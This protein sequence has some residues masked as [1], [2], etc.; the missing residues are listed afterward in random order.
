MYFL[1][2]GES[3]WNKAQANLDAIGMLSD[4]DH[5]LDQTGIQQ[6]QE[7]NQKW[8]DAASRDEDGGQSADG[9][10]GGSED[11]KDFLS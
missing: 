6:C 9:E 10:E 1:R 4:V 11:L 7:F 8:K 5:P 3:E 2:H